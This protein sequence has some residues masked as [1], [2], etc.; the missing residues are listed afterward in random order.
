MGFSFLLKVC[1]I[2]SIEDAIARKEESDYSIQSDGDCIKIRLIE[3][4]GE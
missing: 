1:V 4:F 2:D 3:T